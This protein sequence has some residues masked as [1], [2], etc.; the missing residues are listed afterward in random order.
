MTQPTLDERV[1]RL[2]QLLDRLIDYAR[3]TR[4]GRTIL[5]QLGVDDA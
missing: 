5:A 2:E 1:T 3:R 4:A